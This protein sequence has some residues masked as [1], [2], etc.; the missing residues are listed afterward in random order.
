MNISLPQPTITPISQPFWD[1]IQEKKFYLQCCQ[2]CHKWVFY[3]RAHCPDCFGSDLKWQAASGN[4]KLTTWSVVHRAGH[5]AWQERAPY[6]VGI[7]ELE[8]G[9]SLLTHLL[10]DEQDLYY[11]LP[12][13]INFQS[14]NGFLL[15]FFQ[16][17]G[18]RV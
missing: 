10:I 11:Q 17:K 13:E 1:Y 18:V 15:P 9:P 2:D 8:E 7:V 14:I 3:P 12:V 4:G 6:V 5:P 16:E